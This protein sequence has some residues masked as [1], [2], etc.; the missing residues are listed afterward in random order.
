MPAL[1]LLAGGPKPVSRPAG[2][3]GGGV[4]APGNGWTSGD[5]QN[6]YWG[7]PPEQSHGLLGDIGTGIYN[8]AMFPALMGHAAGALGKRWYDDPGQ[9]NPAQPGSDV[10]RG[11]S[12]L[13]LGLVALIR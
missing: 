13:G 2:L 5:G 9:M 7:V 12:A 3:L 6:G 8:T 10:Q 11:A 4:P 1:G